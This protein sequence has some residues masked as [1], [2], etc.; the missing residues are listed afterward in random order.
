MSREKK[1][2]RDR[3]CG[4]RGLSHFSRLPSRATG[5][6]EPERDLERLSTTWAARSFLSH[7]GQRLSVAVTVGV[8][9][10]RRGD[11]ACTPRPPG[12]TLRVWGRAAAELRR[13]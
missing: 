12:Y 5:R 9:I 11:T 3:A 6:A 1:T 13:G 10:E 4:L 8:A 7:Y 2:D